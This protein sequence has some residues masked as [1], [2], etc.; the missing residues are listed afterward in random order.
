[1]KIVLAL[2]LAAS[3]TANA[4]LFLNRDNAS[5]PFALTRPSTSEKKA[6]APPAFPP[7]TWALITSGAPDS[8]AKLREL[9]L[10]DSVI[11][12]LIRYQVE[13]RYRDRENALRVADDGNFWK[14]DYG[15]FWRSADPLK[16][17]DLRRE[18]AAEMKTLLA[19]L[20]EPDKPGN[21]PRSGF[22]PTTKAE[23]VRLIREDYE[24]LRQPLQS[25]DGITLPEDSEKLAFLEKQ[26]RADLAEA[27]TPEELTAYDLRNSRTAQQLRYQLAAF[28]ATEDEYKTIFALRQA[29]DEKYTPQTGSTVIYSNTQGPQKARDELNAQLK[30]SLGDDRYAAYERAQDYEFRTLASL[31]KRLDLPPEKAVEAHALKTE[32]EKKLRAFRPVPG[33]PA[34]EQRAAYL[35]GLAKEAETSFTAILGEKGYATYKDYGQI[36]R[37]LEPPPPPAPKP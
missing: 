27:L 35:A 33:T 24:A 13:L 2:L 17:L 16:A 26:E 14:R 3:L 10:P 1:M 7:D 11:R 5:A 30:A 25:Y 37:R 31:T 23:Q 32:L 36:F 20:A 15:N 12:S 21:D 8:A 29:Y 22:L 4:L 34:N 18:K 9:G 19:G 28:D 6:P